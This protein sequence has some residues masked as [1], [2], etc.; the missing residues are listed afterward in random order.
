MIRRKSLGS[1]LGSFNKTISQL[2]KLQENND[3]KVAAYERDVAYHE[4]TVKVCKDLISA[5]QAESNMAAEVAKKIET[6]ISA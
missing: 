4:G 1:I 2:K 3:T 6:L 5:T